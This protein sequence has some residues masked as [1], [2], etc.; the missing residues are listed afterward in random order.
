[1]V[2]TET[3]EP[4]PPPG[5][6]VTTLLTE[7]GGKTRIT[8]TVRYE[9]KEV[10]DI[11]LGTGMEKGAAIS[12]DRLEDLVIALRQQRRTGAQAQPASP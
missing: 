12:Y 3:M 2:F 7:E 8:A 11:V 10:R 5:S 4:Y 9:T 6:T 1:M